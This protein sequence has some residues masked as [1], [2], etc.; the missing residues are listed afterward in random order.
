MRRTL[1]VLQVM[2]YAAGVLLFGGDLHKIADLRAD[3]AHCK[4]TE[5]KDLTWVDLVTG[6][7][8]NFDALLDA[9]GH[10]DEQRPHHPLHHGRHTGAQPVVPLTAD[11]AVIAELLFDARPIRFAQFTETYRSDPLAFVFRPPAA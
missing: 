4:A 7:L 10:G 3:L 6:H 9:H 8:V 5:D 1:A 2:I 11:V